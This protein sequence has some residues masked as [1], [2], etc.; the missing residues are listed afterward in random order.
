MKLRLITLI[1]GVICSLGDSSYGTSLEDNPIKRLAVSHNPILR[2]FDSLWPQP[3]KARRAPILRPGSF[4]SNDPT[5]PMEV[6]DEW[7]M[8]RDFLSALALEVKQEVMY[9]LTP[10][11][12]SQL[13]LMR[14]SKDFKRLAMAVD[15][16]RDLEVPNAL[17]KHLL[18]VG[19]GGQTGDV[20]HFMEDQLETFM[21]FDIPTL[22]SMIQ[23]RYF[24]GALKSFFSWKTNY[25]SLR[26]H[27]PFRQYIFCDWYLNYENCG[28]SLV[29][30]KPVHSWSCVYYVDL[31]NNSLLFIPNTFFK[32]L[33]QLEELD[34]SHNQLTDVPLSMNFDRLE[35]FDL[36]HNQLTTLQNLFSMPT[37]SYFSASHNHLTGFPLFL[38]GCNNL[39]ELDLSWNKFTHIP[40]FP[41]LAMLTTL[42]L[43][44]NRLENLPNLGRLT[45]LLR[46]NVSSNKLRSL[47]GIQTLGDLY[48]LDASCN[49]LQGFV[50]FPRNA[51]LKDLNLSQNRLTSMWHIHG[52]RNLRMLNLSFNPALDKL[53]LSS[54]EKL[55]RIFLDHQQ[56]KIP[57][58]LLAIKTLEESY[59]WHSVP[60]Y[61][62]TIELCLDA[63]EEEGNIFGSSLKGHP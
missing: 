40:Y 32:D 13:N 5:I 33:K 26:S 22:M 49:A 50:K 51:K 41:P 42:D 23:K 61:T 29:P 31:S 16:F 9:F 47:K 48:F 58:F 55:E 20:A 27:Y 10:N 63:P 11:P 56:M 30:N 36:S 8:P 54:L 21:E 1:L 6:K 46:L 43:S 62:R 39:N 24:N 38:W 14:A 44:G 4:K 45:S 12:E 18:C 2:I 60:K 37:L 15:G 19:I 52:L 59:V 3:K 28:L 57:Q 53:E 34:L 7:G 35:R 17:R 25:Q